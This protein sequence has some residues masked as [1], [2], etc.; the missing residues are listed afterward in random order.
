MQFL[1]KA[2]AWQL[3]FLILVL[4]FGS[5]FLWFL[6]LG[7]H[8]NKVVPSNIRMPAGLFKFSIYYSL[9]CIFILYAGLIFIYVG[10]SGDCFL[11]IKLSL[12]FVLPCMLYG[13]Y[14][15]SRNLVMAE[16]KQKVVLGNYVV[17]FFLI[18]FYPIGIWFVQPRVN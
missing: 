15:I 13:L 7:I 4:T 6:S 12:Y 14:F 10:G 9:I 2:K 11:F 17:T 5:Q 8:L 16:K 1:L 3:F 18:L